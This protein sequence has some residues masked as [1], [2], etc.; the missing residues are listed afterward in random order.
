MRRRTSRSPH[1]LAALVCAAV[2]ARCATTAVPPRDTFPLDPRDGLGGPFDEAVARGWKALLDGDTAR[3]E[4]EFREAGTARAG[5][6]ASA[7]AAAIGRIE[8][9]VLSK[10][11]SQAVEACQALLSEGEST[12]PLLSACGEARAR[13]ADPVGA[14]E[15]YDRAAA[16]APNRPGLASR[17]EELRRTAAQSLLDEAMANAVAGRRDEARRLVAR[18]VGWS[19][20]TSEVLVRA[21][22]VEC[23]AGDREGALDYYREAMTLGPVDTAVE[24]RAGDIALSLQ[25]YSAAVSIFD[26]LAARDKGFASRAAEARLAFRI[27]NW[28]DAER[29]A[30]RTRRLSRGAAA[31]LVWWLFPEV[32]EARVEAAGVVAT[33]V[34]ERKDSRVM[35]RAVSMGL[36]E[37]DPTTHRARPDALLTRASAARMMVLLASRVSR[38]GAPPAC[39][40]GDPSPG[41]SGREAIRVAA[42]CELLSESGSSVV[43]GV[44]FTRG[45]DRLRS[46]IPAG[47]AMKRD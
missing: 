44:E 32:R 30:A 5:G 23:E 39:F 17:A 15:L 28:P 14:V 26:G 3:A 10:R 46:L 38:P 36:L 1:F 18:A 16:A 12:A 43:S 34:L 40:Q 31:L 45:L 24:E 19:A 21:G 47:E 41:K 22:D 37:V 11:S 9:L 13:T 4:S 29:E 20:H 2:L 7:R 8:V 33:D 27:A 6:S 42:R 35:M 25:D